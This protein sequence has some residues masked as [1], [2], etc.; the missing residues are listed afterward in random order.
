MLKIHEKSQ[1]LCSKEYDNES[2]IAIDLKNSKSRGNVTIN[3]DTKAKSQLQGV[4][5]S[6]NLSLEEA[7]L[8]QDPVKGSCRIL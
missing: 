8:K 7:L 3:A 1:R 5:H 4:V 2:L 6:E